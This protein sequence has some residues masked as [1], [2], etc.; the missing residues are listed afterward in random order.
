MMKKQ[1]RTTLEL[2]H[3]EPNLQVAKTLPAD[4]A[5]RYHALP[6]AKDGE[7]ITVAMADPND[8]KARQAVL[9]TFG[10]STCIVQA[11]LNT[12]DRLLEDLWPEQQSQSLKFLT[13]ITN[14]TSYKDVENFAQTFS[15][16]LGAQLI[17]FETS[18]NGIDIAKDLVEKINLVGADLVIYRAPQQSLIKR[19]V[20]YPDENSLV[21]LLGVSSLIVKRFR[22]PIKQILLVIRNENSDETSLNWTLNLAKKSGAFVT[23]LPI[24]N[25]IPAFY[26]SL[27][28][29]VPSLI[30]S[31]CALGRKMR[32]VANKLLEWEIDGSLR[33]RN[34]LPNDQIRC[35]VLEGDHDL[36]VI[37]ADPENM[38]RRMLVG[39]LVAPL[40]SWADRP[41]LIA[42]PQIIHTEEQ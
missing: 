4:L 29:D 11:D 35:E 13:W 1:I 14:D 18:T 22:W 10:N 41:L 28:Q 25:P 30:S 8:V 17:S 12:I 7:K 2:N 15:A 21:D 36:I 9:A 24:T 42:K 19:L 33:L 38:I 32:W 23:V 26:S 34:E 5:R 27:P 31:D 37:A 16:I 39:T 3:L 40:L 20:G 6:V